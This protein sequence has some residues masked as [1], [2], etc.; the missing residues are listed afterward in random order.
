[1]PI[2]LILG[3]IAFFVLSWWWHRS[4]TLTR[5][6]KWREDR[7]RAAAG[8][9]FFHCVACGAETELPQGEQPRHCLRPR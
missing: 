9:S 5:D 2:I 8:Q 6:C 1:M 3:L 7:S 4:R